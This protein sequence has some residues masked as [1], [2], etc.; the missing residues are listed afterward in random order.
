MKIRGLKLAVM[1]FLLAGCNSNVLLDEF[2]PI[3]KTG[4][5]YNDQKS[6]TVTIEDS[7]IYYNSFINL[8][9]R[10]DYNY[11]NIYVLLHTGSESNQLKTER[12]QFKLANDLGRW[13]G[14]GIGDLHEYR[15]PLYSNMELATGEYSFTIEQNM[16]DSLLLGVSDVGFSIEKG[17]PV[18]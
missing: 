16:R 1:A 4:W 2:K 7:S 10:D 8:R 15:L 3:D 9:I 11:A 14:K 13:Q 5:S 6:F 17:G 18:F 12:F